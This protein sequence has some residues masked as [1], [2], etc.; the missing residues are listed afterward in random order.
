MNATDAAMQIKA[1]R[2]LVDRLDRVS[3]PPHLA[4]TYAMNRAKVV[5]ADDV[6]SRAEL[7]L[8]PLIP[9]ALT[10]GA[11]IAGAYGL[12]RVGRAVLD[13]VD[14][15]IDKVGNAAI[16]TARIITYVLGGAVAALAFGKARRSFA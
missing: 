4:Q 6:L 16:D 12:F 2:R 11:G 9:L 7:G 14:V 3:M 1:A 13:K 8:L 10:L 5:Q 15:G